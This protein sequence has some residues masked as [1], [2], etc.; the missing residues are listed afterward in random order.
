[1]SR[2]LFEQYSPPKEIADFGSL[3]DKVKS[4]EKQIEETRERINERVQQAKQE[5]RNAEFKA[6]SYQESVEQQKQIAE[7]LD[8]VRETKTRLGAFSSF[9]EAQLITNGIS[10]NFK[11][12]ISKR[13]AL[14]TAT[15]QLYGKPQDVITYEMYKELKALKAKMEREE[16]REYVKGDWSTE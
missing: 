16:S 14:R 10:P 13:R 9:L 7:A 4:P 11:L 6:L 3:A 5:A 1:M 2:S 12:N 15:K 8:K